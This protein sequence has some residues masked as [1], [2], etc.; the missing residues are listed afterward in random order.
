MISD[1]KSDPRI[2]IDGE[3]GKRRQ[4]PAYKRWQSMHRWAAV[5]TGTKITITSA[6]T[7]HQQSWL[8]WTAL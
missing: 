4:Y 7:S 3:N 5:A 1:M 8:L 2:I 6:Q